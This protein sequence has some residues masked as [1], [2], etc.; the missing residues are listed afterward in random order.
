MTPLRL[1]WN[2]GIRC[3]LEGPRAVPLSS[4][5]SCIFK[6]L[7]FYPPPALNASE[8][9]TRYGVLADS[10]PAAA[11]A[12]DFNRAVSTSGS[13]AAHLSA[14]TSSVF[15]FLSFFLSSSSPPP[16]ISAPAVPLW[17]VLS[18]QGFV[19]FAEPQHIKGI[20]GDV[21]VTSVSPGYKG[22]FLQCVLRASG[23]ASPSP[24]PS[25]SSPSWPTNWNQTGVQG[26]SG[27]CLTTVMPSRGNKTLRILKCRPP[28]NGSLLRV[29]RDIFVCVVPGSVYYKGVA[30]MSRSCARTRSAE[31]GADRAPFVYQPPRPPTHL[32][33]VD[34][35]SC[36]RRA[37]TLSCA[38]TFAPRTVLGQSR[39][40]GSHAQIQ[41][42]CRSL[43]TVSSVHLMLP[44]S[45]TLVL[46]DVVVSFFCFFVFF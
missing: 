31:D 37:D 28:P 6:L 8:S 20:P 1:R 18:M 12:N 35:A 5:S 41:H 21:E 11:T 40:F 44:A 24:P 42:V 16:S 39:G 45:L 10:Q 36:A 33:A 26:L 7:R 27:A 29:P 23:A 19:S 32:F 2:F 13:V 46:V 4:P 9:V 25:S 43:A 34:S 14:V 22:F 3:R 38:R 17:P 15:P 30:V